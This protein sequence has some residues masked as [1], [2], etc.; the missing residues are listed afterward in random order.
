MKTHTLEWSPVARYEAPIR[1]NPARRLNGLLCLAS[2]A[3]LALVPALATIVGATWLVTLPDSALYLQALVWT[4]GFVFLGLALQSESADAAIL[5]LATG[6][7]LPVLALLSSR[8]GVDL[9]IVAATL[10]AAWIASS[11]VRWRA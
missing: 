10:I 4:G 1:R 11:V 8:F 6:V 2:R 9:L 7:T 5:A 3:L